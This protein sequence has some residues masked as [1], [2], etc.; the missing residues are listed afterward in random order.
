MSMDIVERVVA[1]QKTVDAI[2]GKEMKPGKVDCIQLTLTHAKHMRRRI[3]IPPYGDWVSAANVLRELGFATLGEALSHYFTRIEPVRAM[4]SDYIEMP[5]E[6]GFSSIAVSVG[7]G[8]VIGFHSSI[9]HADILQPMIITG[10]W[11][12]E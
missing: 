11:R 2:K 6:N 3:S 12:I 10:A 1:T 7:N 8:R 5:G 4:V 9:P